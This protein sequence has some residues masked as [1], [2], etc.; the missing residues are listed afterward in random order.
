VFLL[1]AVAFVSA[2]A[3]DKPKA[4]LLSAARPVKLAEASR[5]HLAGTGI[6]VMHM[7]ITTGKVTSVEIQKS[8]GQQLLDRSAVQALQKWRFTPGAVRRVVVPV[9]FTASDDV[10][11]Y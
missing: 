10:G 1:P 7:D 4:Q 11:K 3:D 8:T 9:S 5:L 2:S 6:F